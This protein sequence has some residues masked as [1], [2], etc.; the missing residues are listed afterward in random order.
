[1]RASYGQGF[2]YPTIAEKFIQTNVGTVYI[3]PN[4]SLQ[5]ESGWSAELGLKQGLKMGKWLGY[6]DVAAFWTRY[7]NM[8]EF[9]FGQ[10]G[11][12]LKD[13]LF[14]LGF[15][16][17]NIGDAA[18]SGLDISLVGEG[19]IGPVQTKVLAGLTYMNPVDDNTDSSYN[20]QKSPPFSNFLKY[21]YQYLGK[22]DIEFSY[23]RTSFGISYRYNSFMKAVDSA[24]VSNLSGAFTSVENWRNKHETGDYFI[25]V[26]CSYLICKTSKIA[27][28][29]KNLMNRVV[30]VRPGDIYPP[31][32]FVLQYTLDF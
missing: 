31:R 9:T 3:Y 4:D 7:H 22:A 18:I 23:Q 25:D 16:S 14:G 27:F 17:K 32:S 5:P 2:R 30:M 21:R 11:N 29:I 8:M 20:K 12:P 26:R 19:K 24:F 13:P 28:I 15:E 1:L 10:Y 6:F